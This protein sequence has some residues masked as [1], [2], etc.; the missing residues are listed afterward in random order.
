MPKLRPADQ[1]DIGEKQLQLIK[2]IYDS[3]PT[4]PG[5]KGTVNVLTFFTAIRKDPQIRTINSAIARDPDGCS[6]IVQ[7]TFKEVFDRMERELQQKQVDWSTIV[8]FFTKRG[9]PLSKDEI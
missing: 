6:R 5:G 7:E 2:D 8:E 9:R 1:I 3:I 4:A